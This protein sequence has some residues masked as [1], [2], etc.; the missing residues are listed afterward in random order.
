M[1][2]KLNCILLIDDE[3][4]DNFFHERTIRKVDCTE[5]VVARENGIDALEYLTTLEDGKY[6]QPDLIFLDINMPKMNGWEFLEEY[7][8]LDFAQKGNVVLVMLSTSLNPDDEKRANHNENIN[9]FIKKPL[10]KE[11]LLEILEENF[12]DYF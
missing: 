6:P 2:R 5:K 11:K 12:P 3:E 10:S 4:P 1:K 8:K 7:E 9:N